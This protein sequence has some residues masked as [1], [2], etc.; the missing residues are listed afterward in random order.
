MHE[1]DPRWSKAS[2]IALGG[3]IVL[4]VLVPLVVNALAPHPVGSLY[5]DPEQVEDFTLPRADGGTFRLSDYRGETVVLYFG[6][7]SCPDVCPTTL[8]DLRRAKAELGNLADDVEFVFI[9]VDPTIDEAETI[10]QYLSHFD[11]SF[12]G[13]YGTEDQILTVADRFDIVTKGADET[14]ATYGITHTTSTFIIDSEGYLKMRMHYG[15][16][17]DR[18]ADDI[19]L[20]AKGRI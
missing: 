19:K 14:V 4:L 5:D 3:V 16:P 20:V 15:Q 11:E 8:Y 18:M 2:P 12:I 9:T 1:E 6:Y 13:L 17:Y 7:T 10:T